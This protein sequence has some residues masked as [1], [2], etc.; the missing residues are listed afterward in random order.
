VGRAGGGAAAITVFLVA[1]VLVAAAWP[2]TQVDPAG[3]PDDDRSPAV[4]PAPAVPQTALG[5]LAESMAPGTWA[6]LPTLDMVP[7]L[8]ADGASGSILGY[9]EDGGWDPT[10]RQFLFVGCDHFFTADGDRLRFVAYSA[11]TNAWRILPTPYWIPDGIN[12]GYDHNAIDPVHSRFYHRTYAT[13]SV[14]RYDIAADTW[15][16]L[17]DIPG[18]VMGYNNCCMGLEYFP[19]LDGLILAGST[20]SGVSDEAYLYSDG[21]GQWSRI[22]DDSPMGSY[23]HFV[24]YNPVHRLVLFGGGTDNNRQLHSISATGVVTHHADAPIPLGVQNAIVTVDPVG[25]DFLVLGKDGG[26]F[27]YDVLADAWSVVPGS[28]PIFFPVR[29]PNLV[30]QTVAAPVS[31][32]GV[33]MFVKFYFDGAGSQAWVYLY[34][35][36]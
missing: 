18:S 16:P 19:E 21:T 26:F 29:G 14:Y 30:W 5:L 6:E 13:R 34:K 20:D 9:A 11:D 3:H 4:V 35:A 28:V 7:T 1:V 24:E 33:T 23:N 27:E 17:P 31:T 22:A 36:S 10:T 32:Y 12:H 8:I 15:T 25:G 2:A